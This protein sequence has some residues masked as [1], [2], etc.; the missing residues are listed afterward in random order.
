MTTSLQN[1]VVWITGA[2]TGIGRAM[3]HAFAAQGARIALTGRRADAL[4]AVETALRE[5]GAAVMTAQADVTGP[6][7]VT[8]AHAAIAAAWG[9]VD[10]LVNNAGGNAKNRHWRNLSAADMAAIVDVNLKGPF[11]CTLAVLPAM[12]ARRDGL[13]IHVASLAGTA[14]FPVTGATYTAAK[15][16]VRAMSQTLNA[17]E[18]IHGIRSVCINPGEV[19]TDILNSRP[20][21][22]SAADRALMVQP[23]DIA[24]AAVFAA[25][26]PARACIADMTMVPTDNQFH[27]ATARAI[28]EA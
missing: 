19:E 20:N 15:H 4:A 26:L 22:P 12:R 16:G 18:G 24:A 5:S 17:E 28:A 14:I 13:L 9:E 7:Q 21:P 3:A 6:A 27:R 25:T 8:A 2:G 10:I 11:L 23:E 1:R